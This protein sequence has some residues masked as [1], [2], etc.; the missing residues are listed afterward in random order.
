M[1]ARQ[2]S[3]ETPIYAP[4]PATLLVLGSGLLGLRLTRFRRRQPEF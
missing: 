2:F 1:I 4:E 3:S